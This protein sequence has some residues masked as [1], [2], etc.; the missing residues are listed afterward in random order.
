MSEVTRAANEAD[1]E[2]E[3]PMKRR[4]GLALIGSASC[5]ESS[6][7]VSKSSAEVIMSSMADIAAER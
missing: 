5:E 4:I 3:P 7:A 1:E 6:Y 2:A